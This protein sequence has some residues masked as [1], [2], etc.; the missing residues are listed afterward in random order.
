MP[1]L[2]CTVTDVM[3]VSAYPPI[4]DMVLMSDWIPA[5]PVLSEPVMLNTGRFAIVG[6]LVVGFWL[7]VFGYGFLVMGCYLIAVWRLSHCYVEAIS[8]LCG[9]YLIAM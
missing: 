3:A 8:L 7:W 5:L 1:W 9:H 4:A 2:F 6:W